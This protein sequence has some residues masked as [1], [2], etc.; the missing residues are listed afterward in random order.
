[1]AH[2]VAGRE[3]LAR[4]GEPAPHT[5]ARRPEPPTSSAV[6]C[7]KNLE[8]AVASY[9]ELFGYTVSSGP[10]DDQTQKVSVC[11][12]R[13]QDSD[14]LVIE[15]VMPACEDSPVGQVLA[16]GFHHNQLIQTI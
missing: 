14:R 10:F 9:R 11:F 6:A 7:G 8:R 13:S 1:M 5:D 12:L 3:R 2:T 4:R 16:K 15:L